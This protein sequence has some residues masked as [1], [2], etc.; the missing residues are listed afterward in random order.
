[1][2]CTWKTTGLEKLLE[3]LEIVSSLLWRLDRCKL[4]RVS[5]DEITSWL[6]DP[7][8]LN[9]KKICI[10]QN[11]LYLIPDYIILAYHPFKVRSIIPL[12]SVL[13]MTAETQALIITTPQETFSF[14]FDSTKQAADWMAELSSSIPLKSYVCTK[15][16]DMNLLKRITE[17][18]VCFRSVCILCECVHV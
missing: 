15:C 8:N 6:L 13:H 10:D 7:K 11:C 9:I 2:Y 18:S 5:A 4:D 1:M 12:S 14:N 16:K 17:C 3:V